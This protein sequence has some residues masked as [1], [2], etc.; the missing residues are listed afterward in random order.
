MKKTYKPQETQL[1]KSLR[2]T[3]IIGFLFLG[4]FAAASWFLLLSPRI[5]EP[6]LLQQTAES[7][8]TQKLALDTQVATLE[9]RE[10]YLD[11]AQA[12]AQQ[13]ES[14]FPWEPDVPTLIQQV[15]EAA[16]RAGM[17]VNQ[18]LSVVPGKPTSE[19]ILVN[20]GGGGGA[21][22]TPPT[23]EAGGG[24][25]GGEAGGETGGEEEAPAPA[26][27]DAP[28]T[29][30][31]ARMDVGITVAG[32]YEQIAE[33]LLQLRTANRV[34]VV[35]SVRLTIAPSVDGVPVTNAYQADIDAYAVL[36]PKPPS[37][38]KPV[39][40]GDAGVPTDGPSAPS[41]GETV[42]EASN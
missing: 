30:A 20:G 40:Q 34:I 23:E 21:P 19:G 17:P 42:N 38:P 26:T 7:A 37:P 5:S 33:F 2:K 28:A 12:A 4:V 39:T 6:A 15:Q 32:T 27:P 9:R 16:L 14:R 24:E 3:R 36:L 22:S 31:L 10:R 13:L 11:E 1:N 8:L 18:I 41:G 29:P 25:A 35:E